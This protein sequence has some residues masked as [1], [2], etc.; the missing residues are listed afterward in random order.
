MGKYNL[1]SNRE[2]WNEWATLHVETE[3]Y[4]VEG[5][6]NGRCTLYPIE[7]EE[8]GDV[9]GK[10]LL[11]LMC[12]FGMDTISWARRGAKVTGM[13]F[14][15]NAIDIVRSLAGGQGVCS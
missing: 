13:D 12:H 10:S 6:K 15:D 3:H 14:S 5:F 11:H 4:D 9:K 1:G 7:V 2:M 8:I